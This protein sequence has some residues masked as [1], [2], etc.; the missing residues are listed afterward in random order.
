[1]D[2]R[3]ETPRPRSRSEG[4]IRAT[5]TRTPSALSHLRSRRAAFATSLKVTTSANLKTAT[6]VK[7]AE[8]W[9]YSSTATRLNPKCHVKVK[10]LCLRFTVTPKSPKTKELPDC[11]TPGNSQKCP[12][13]A[14]EDIELSL[15]KPPPHL[16]TAPLRSRLPGTLASKSAERIH[17][18]GPRLVSG[19]PARLPPRQTGFNPRPDNY[20]IFTSG[21]LAGR[22]RWS[23]SFLGG[24][25]ISL[26]FA[27]QLCFSSRFISFIPRNTMTNR[28]VIILSSCPGRVASLLP[29]KTFGLERK[30]DERGGVGGSRCSLYPALPN[31]VERPNVSH[32]RNVMRSTSA[33]KLVLK[34]EKLKPRPRAILR[35]QRVFSPQFEEGGQ[36]RNRIPIRGAPR[37]GREEVTC[38]GERSRLRGQELE[39]PTGGGSLKSVLFA[40]RNCSPPENMCSPQPE[41][42]SIHDD[43]GSAVPKHTKNLTSTVAE[44]YKIDI[45]T[46]L[47]KTAEEINQQCSI[48]YSSLFRE[49]QPHAPGEWHHCQVIPPEIETGSPCWEAS[50]LAAAAPWPH[51]FSDSTVQRQGSIPGGVAPGFPDVRIVPDDAAGRRVSSGISLSPAITSRSCS[52]L[53]SKAPEEEPRLGQGTED[54]PARPARVATYSGRDSGPKVGQ[55]AL[56][57]NDV[58]LHS[59]RRTRYGHHNPAVPPHVLRYDTPKLHVVLLKN[60]ETCPLIGHSCHYSESLFSSTGSNK[61]ENLDETARYPNLADLQQGMMKRN[62]ALI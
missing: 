34:A 33:L 16:S 62:I 8:T 43:L 21:N 3:C 25:L 2:P 24:S 38:R 17:Y 6:A 49:L 39:R 35:S 50:S 47:R 10:V 36:P 46:K 40:A 4:A 57:H 11:R 18:L 41:R 32:E 60:P 23:A 9:E 53:T 14:G 26:P 13:H 61:W 56:C 1:M 12:D 37:N 29:I 45:E 55:R 58:G 7:C 28:R 22:Y 19:W 27:F 30:G 31:S 48:S 5:I 59:S 15:I 42:G 44:G 20:R 52:I 51:P 54:R